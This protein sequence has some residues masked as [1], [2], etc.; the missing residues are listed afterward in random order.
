MGHARKGAQS[1]PVP[2]SVLVGSGTRATEAPGLLG[3][4]GHPG[5]PSH[6]GY[7]PDGTQHVR[8]RH[9]ASETWGAPGASARLPESGA[10]A[11]N[12]G[13]VACGAHRTTLGTKEAA[14][15]T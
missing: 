12:D 8:R 10:H 2:H 7:P 6:H 15:S 4:T 14:P 1:S 13:V 9:R 11:R 5:T 3:A